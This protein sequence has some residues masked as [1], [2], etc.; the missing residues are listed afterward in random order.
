MR[1]I[2]TNAG[3]RSEAV[4]EVL[5]EEVSQWLPIS[6]VKVLSAEECKK[7]IGE[8]GM[9]MLQYVTLNNW[10]AF[11]LES[12]L[13]PFPEDSQMRMITNLFTGIGLEFWIPETGFAWMVA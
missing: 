6:N 9:G 8:F 1:V 5:T 13:D 3:E 4:A 2:V 10:V 7:I 12:G 11:N